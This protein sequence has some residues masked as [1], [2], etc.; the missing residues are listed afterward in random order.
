MANVWIMVHIKS[1]CK[2]CD[3]EDYCTYGQQRGQ[4]TN[5]RCLAPASGNQN[6]VTVQSGFQA[7]TST[8][9]HL[10]HLLFQ[11]EVHFLL[12]ICNYTE[13]EGSTWPGYLKVTWTFHIYSPGSPVLWS[14]LQAVQWDDHEWVGHREYHPDVNHLDITSHRQRIPDTHETKKREK[15]VSSGN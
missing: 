12:K 7:F 15:I 5:N 8:C 11:M 2:I 4:N 1:N 6:T 13:M 3:G 14:L 9:N 10:E